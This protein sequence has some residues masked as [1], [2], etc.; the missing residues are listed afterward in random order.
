MIKNGQIQEN[1]EGIFLNSQVTQGNALPKHLG[2][3]RITVRL[4]K[5]YFKGK[6]IRLHIYDKIYFIHYNHVIIC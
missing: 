2:D 5:I 6:K 1:N 4:W 3:C